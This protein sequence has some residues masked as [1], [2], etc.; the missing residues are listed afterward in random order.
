MVVELE[1]SHSI[2][3]CG[4]PYNKL[5]EIGLFRSDPLGAWSRR[6]KRLT[7][8]WK[9]PCLFRLAVFTDRPCGCCLDGIRAGEA[10]PQNQ[11]RKHD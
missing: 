11:D 6:S 4:E 10:R 1:L 9:D 7:I 2:C 8:L 5:L 3:I